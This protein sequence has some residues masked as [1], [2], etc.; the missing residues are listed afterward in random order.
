MPQVLVAGFLVAHGLITSL[1]GAGGIASPTSPALT[2]PSW[3]GWWPGPFGRSWLFDAVGLGPGALVVG[4]L[5]WLAAGLALVGA[6]LGWLG[7][8]GLSAAWQSLALAGALVGLASLALYFHPF[9]LVAIVIDVAIVVLI[10]R[11]TVTVQ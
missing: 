5:V 10:S 3:L 7:I 8:P 9:Y 4:S 11:A 2:M 6:G 1:I